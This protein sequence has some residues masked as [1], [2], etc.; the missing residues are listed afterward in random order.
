[1]T[2]GPG[3]EGGSWL[4]IRRHFDIQ[5]FG[6]NAYR[7]DAGTRVIEEHDELGGSA[8]RHEELYVVLAGRARFT[9]GGDELDAPAGTALFVPPET[10]RGALAE[11]DDT[12][13][14]AIGGKS[15]EPFRV[16]P[17]EAA[18]DAWSAYEAKDYEAASD[19]FERVVDVYPE[20]AGL[21]YNLACCEALVGRGD[22]AVRDLRRAIELEERFR[23]FARDDEDFASIRDRPDVRELLGG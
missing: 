1:V 7:A 20:A 21:R 3:A 4:Q 22:A 12:T 10:R 2:A 14:L 11:E 8:G 18:A 16:S 9:V 19:V 5:A 15:G 6:V 17:W 23:E 13:V